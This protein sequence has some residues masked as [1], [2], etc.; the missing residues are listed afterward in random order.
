[1]GSA[2][3]TC[4]SASFDLACVGV[5]LSTLRLRFYLQAPGPEFQ[6]LECSQVFQSDDGH[7]SW[8]QALAA[9]LH[10]HVVLVFCA[11]VVWQIC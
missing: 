4:N 6:T 3:A 7:Q 2:L 10:D 1:M 9:C 8:V 11:K 5:V